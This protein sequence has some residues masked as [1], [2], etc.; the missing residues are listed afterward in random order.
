[1]SS[2]HGTRAADSSF[3]AEVQWK[4]TGL[5]HIYPIQ[6]HSR[7]A[8]VWPYDQ[9]SYD[10]KEIPDRVDEHGALRNK[11]LANVKLPKYIQSLRYVP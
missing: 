8:N 4:R 7:S 1:M 2:Y 3:R 9:P 10:I 6:E 11:R 5:G